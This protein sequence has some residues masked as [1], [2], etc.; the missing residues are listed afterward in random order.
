MNVYE[1]ISDYLMNS[2]YNEN[3]LASRGALAAIVTEYDA[4]APTPK[5][6]AVYPNAM[7]YVIEINGDALWF[8]DEPQ[9]NGWR[10][11]NADWFNDVGYEHGR[12]VDLPEGVDPRLC[13]WSRPE[14]T[15]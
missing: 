12:K 14:V 15:K 7:W 4:L 11:T 8:E 5:D 9:H 13:K 3:G 6:W 2:M 10:W 1:A